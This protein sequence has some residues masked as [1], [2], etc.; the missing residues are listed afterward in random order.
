MTLREKL[1]AGRQTLVTV[2]EFFTPTPFSF[3]KDIYKAQFPSRL[4]LFELSFSLIRSRL[5]VLGA[6][7]VARS[8]HDVLG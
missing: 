3:R 8:H 1:G 5:G 7:G 6:R 2:V 4:R